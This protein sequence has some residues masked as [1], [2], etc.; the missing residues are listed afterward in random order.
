MFLRVVES[1]SRFSYHFLK[2]TTESSLHVVLVRKSTHLL[3]Y[4][5]WEE[6]SYDTQQIGSVVITLTLR[7]DGNDSGG[8]N[9][10]YNMFMGGMGEKTHEKLLGVS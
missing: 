3:K 9:V 10:N 7:S 5:W 2:T 4:I 6:T 1:D 8:N